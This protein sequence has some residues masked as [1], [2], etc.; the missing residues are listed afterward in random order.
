MIATVAAA[1]ALSIAVQATPER[2]FVTA[3]DEAPASSVA[4]LSP[5]DSESAASGASLLL[6]PVAGDRESWETVLT[7]SETLRRDGDDRSARQVLKWLLEQDLPEDLAQQAARSLAELPLTRQETGPAIRLAL[8]QTA[9]GAYLLGPHLA[10]FFQSY[11]AT[12]YLLG[13]L[14]GGAAG[15]SSA[16]LMAAGPGL[17]TNQATAIIASQQLGGANG[18]VLGMAIASR[19]DEGVPAGVLL[20][21]GAGTAAGYLLASRR[22]DAGLTA[23]THSGMF[24][25]LGVGATA[26]AVSYTFETAETAEAIAIPL[27]LAADAGAAAGWALARATQV[28]PT[29][30]RMMNLGGALGAGTGLLFVAMTG[31]LIWWSPHAVAWTLAGCGVAGGG[32]GL[33]LSRSG[34]GRLGSRAPVGTALISGQPGALGAS[35]PVPTVVSAPDGPAPG[36][37]LVEVRF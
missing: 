5:T 33:A 18:A 22:P 37:S 32:L 14:A 8:W 15:A 21:A 12:P 31:E 17:G 3:T 9:T 26:L 19:N 6:T 36:V 20:G 1:L 24:W 13:A 28:G 4:D 34:S 35:V 23:A 2:T 29:Q 10:Y 30:V 11:E 27:V 7:M 16:L 25:G